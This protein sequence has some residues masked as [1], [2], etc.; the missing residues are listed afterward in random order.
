MKQQFST[1]D[2]VIE[3]ISS[4]EWRRTASI[5]GTGTG[6]L[7]SS[8]PSAKGHLRICNGAHTGLDQYPAGC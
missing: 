2:R 1:I 3:T 4:N 6:A 7:R 8:T 5:T